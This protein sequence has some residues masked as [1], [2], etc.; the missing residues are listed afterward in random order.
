MPGVNM[1]LHDLSLS[2]N[3]YKV[4]LFS[5]LNQID[6][7]VVPVDF[8]GGAHRQPPLIELNPFGEIPVLED[9]ELAL[10]DSQAILVYL[11][12]KF[13]RT[14]WLPADAGGEAQVM[15]WLSTAANEVQHGPGD[16]RLIRKFGLPLDAARARTQS[17][18]ILGL[19]DRH[20]ASRAWLAL[21]RPT[22]ADIAV[23]PYVALS[24]EG[25][26]GLAPYPAIR[27]WIRRISRLPGFVPMPG[28]DLCEDVPA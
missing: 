23:F 25:G 16:A 18:R 12:R 8:L 17:E 21:A 26:I 1:R 9:G 11:A 24:H 4:V 13:A 6:L 3:C 20:L 7:E 27:A 2:G 22:I 15:Q 19:L 28:L 10:R 5:A 14:D